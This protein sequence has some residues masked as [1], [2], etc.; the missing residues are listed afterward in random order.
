MGAGLPVTFLV[1]FFFVIT[2][3]VGLMVYWGANRMSKVKFKRDTDPGHYR[4]M[5]KDDQ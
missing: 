1:I 2:L 3:L 5:P 4:G